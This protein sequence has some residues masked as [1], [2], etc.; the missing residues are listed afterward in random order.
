MLRSA[1]SWPALVL[2]QARGGGVG[3]AL[4]EEHLKQAPARAVLECGVA[5]GARVALQGRR[6]AAAHFDLDR[7]QGPGSFQSTCG[8]VID[9]GGPGPQFLRGAAAPLPADLTRH[10][11]PHWDTGTRTAQ[12]TAQHLIQALIPTLLRY[13]GSFDFLKM[14]PLRALLG[15][16]VVLLT[17][18][19]TAAARGQHLSAA[20]GNDFAPQV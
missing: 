19:W 18:L 20:G 1:L 17:A 14:R 4:P 3:A 7:M 12:H 2:L 8:P 9:T 10:P 5:D 16:M 6:K 15:L 11:V 13:T